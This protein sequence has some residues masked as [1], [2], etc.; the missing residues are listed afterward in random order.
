MFLRDSCLKPAPTDAIGEVTARGGAEFISGVRND[1][2]A[3]S[4]GRGRLGECCEH[5]PQVDGKSWCNEE[6]IVAPPFWPIAEKVRMAMDEDCVLKA[7]FRSSRESD[8]VNS[9]DY[10]RAVGADRSGEL[11]TKCFGALSDMRDGHGVETRLMHGAGGVER[12]GR[13]VLIV[14]GH[15]YNRRWQVLFCFACVI[16]A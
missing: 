1:D 10:V 16:G 15:A 12:R 6:V 4:C 14:G 9:H 5:D 7:G 8:D 3:L 2:D 11:V 13:L